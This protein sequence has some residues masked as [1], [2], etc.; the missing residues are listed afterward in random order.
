MLVM[1]WRRQD[2]DP[3]A[4]ETAHI[5][6]RRVEVKL[7]NQNIAVEIHCKLKNSTRDNDEWRIQTTKHSIMGQDGIE[8]YYHD[9]L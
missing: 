2:K 1:K 8:I 4:S 7:R 5:A 6:N 3:N 9:R